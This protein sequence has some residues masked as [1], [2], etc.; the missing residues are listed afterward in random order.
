MSEG[1]RRIRRAARLLLIDEQER[2]LLIRFAPP[3]RRAFWCGVGG[4][5]DPDEDY[6]A[7]AVRE[8]FEETGLS[9]GNCGPEI[10][11]RTDDFITLEGEPVTSDERFFCVRTTSFTPD[12][13][14]HTDLE[15]ALIKEFRWFTAAEL[16]EWHEPVFPVNILDL[17]QAERAT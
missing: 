13:A 8:L 7:A 11:R 3:T 14:G 12:S 5:C 9:V 1:A 6:H 17:L 4:E 2:L 16:A 10:A 15:R